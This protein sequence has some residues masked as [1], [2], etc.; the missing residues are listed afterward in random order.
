VARLIPPATNSM[1]DKI[2]VDTNI[3][4]YA[5]DLDAG[6]KRVKALAVVDRLWDE[7]KGALSTQVLAEFFVTITRKVKQP[8]PLPAARQIIEDYQTGWTVFPTTPEIVLQAI[9]G[10]AQHRMSFWD[11]MIWAAAKLNG[12]ITIYSEDAQSAQTIEGVRIENP[13]LDT[14]N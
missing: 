5:Y 9:D 6:D 13:L 4:V 11:A 1:S 3:L 2:F 8:L 10:V 14:I 7:G 12:V